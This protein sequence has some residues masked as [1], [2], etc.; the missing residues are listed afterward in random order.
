MP[1]IK[2]QNGP[3]FFYVAQGL[4]T[5]LDETQATFIHLSTLA[6]GNYFLI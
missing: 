6:K 5:I 3:T 2:P 1:G 4:H